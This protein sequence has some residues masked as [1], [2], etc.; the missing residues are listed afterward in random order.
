MDIPFPHTEEIFKA[1]RH[2]FLLTHPFVI[3]SFTPFHSTEIKPQGAKT[4]GMVGMGHCFDNI[5]V[6]AAAIQGMRVSD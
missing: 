5:V 6:H 4:H 1:S 3:L 2:I